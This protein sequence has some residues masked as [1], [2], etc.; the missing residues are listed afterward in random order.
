MKNNVSKKISAVFLVLAIGMVVFFTFQSPKASYDLSMSVKDW[1]AGHG[2]DI[3]Y[4][5]LRT[6]AHLLEYFILGLALSLFA[7]NRGYK[8][9][10]PFTA[11]CGMGLLDETVKVFLPGREFGRGDLIRD[12]VGVGVATAVVMVCSKATVSE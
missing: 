11:G 6:N 3:E 8:W 7:K 5:A 12:I 1:L 10:I 4:S 9:W 2:M